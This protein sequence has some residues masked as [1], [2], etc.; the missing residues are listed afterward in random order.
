L[1]HSDVNSTTVCGPFIPF[2]FNCGNLAVVEAS[3]T[4][5]LSTVNATSGVQAGY[6]WQAANWVFGAE[7]DS[8]SLRLHDSNNVTSAYAGTTIPFTTSTS[9]GTDWLFTARGRLGWTAT[10]QLLLYATG[11]LALSRITVTNAFQDSAGAVPAASSSSSDRAGWTVGGGA[12][13]MFAP[14]WTIRAE[15]L[16]IDWAIFRRPQTLQT[17]LDCQSVP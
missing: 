1:G 2:Y 9:I 16:Y 17:P 11:G 14:H 10:P 15:Y 12:E 7:V 6:N 3:G 4:G 5:S 8:E 13:W